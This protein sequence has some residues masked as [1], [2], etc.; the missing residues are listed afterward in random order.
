MGEADNSCDS[1]IP[2]RFVES[3]PA[4]LN[5]NIKMFY[6]SPA[7]FKFLYVLYMRYLDAK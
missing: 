3:F 2:M 1:W 5:K 7:G 6:L 4:D